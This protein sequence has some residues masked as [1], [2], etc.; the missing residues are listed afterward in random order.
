MS[1]KKKKKFKIK[2]KRVRILKMVDKTLDTDRDK[3]I[4]EIEDLHNQLSQV[5]ILLYKKGRKRNSAK[6][7]KQVEE[8]KKAI[9]VDIINKMEGTNL[10]ERIISI[11]SDISPIV[12]L[13]ARLVAALI[14]A[15][16]SIPSVKVL[17]KPKTL[18]LLNNIYDKSMRISEVF[19]AWLF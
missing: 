7:L 15:V 6:Y 1:K 12:V 8:K 17:I 16:L 13:I 19:P 10:L 2:N 11:I 18:R 3:I 5:D 4:K 14:L 9:R